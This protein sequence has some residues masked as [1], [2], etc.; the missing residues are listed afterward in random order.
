MY[1]PAKLHQNP[2]VKEIVED[3]S[4]QVKSNLQGFFTVATNYQ[5][6]KLASKLRTFVETPENLTMLNAYAIG[7]APSGGG[8]NFSMNRI[9]DEYLEGFNRG[10]TDYLMP[11]T[12]HNKILELA[13]RRSVMNNTSE[14]DEISK[15]QKEL[16]ATGE[17]LDIAEKA[18]P[19]A[20]LQFRQQLLINNCG[21]LNI[22]VDEVASA[23]NTKEFQDCI[24]PLLTLY[25]KGKIE[26]SLVKN[27]NDAKRFSKIDGVTPVNSFFM[28]TPDTL[29]GDDAKCKILADTLST[30]FARRSIFSFEDTYER[31][32]L[33]P[34]ERV[35]AVKKSAGGKDFIKKMNR[36]FAKFA[37]MSKF[38]QRIKLTD[39]DALITL[40]AYTD[41]CLKEAEQYDSAYLITNSPSAILKAEL[42]NREQRIIRFAALYAFLENK[43]YVE[44]DH[45]YQAIHL[46]EMSGEALKKIV[47]KTPIYEM[48]AKY[49]AAQS[50]E[51]VI[52]DLIEAFHNFPKS[53]SDREECLDNAQAWGQRNNIVIKRRFQDKIQYISGE[54]LQ[55][56]D[57]NKLTVA[58]SNH[59]AYD[60]T[61]GEMSWEKL[62][63]F[64]QKPRL[65]WINHHL[66][67]TK[68]RA[69][70]NVVEGFNLL[71]LDVD[72]TC[73]LDNA[74]H[75]MQEYQYLIYTTKRHGQDDKDR[76]RIVLPMLYNIKLNA[77]D[78]KAFMK[79]VYEWL[80]FDVDS[81]TGQ[82]ARKWLTNPGKVYVN[83]GI[84]I[85]PL[86]F[87]PCTK[88]NEMHQQQVKSQEHLNNI[89]RWI[90]NRADTEAGRN[91]MLARYAFILV[92]NGDSFANV[93]SKILNIN[94]QL[95]CPLS[96]SELNSTVFVTT[97]ERIH[98][99][100][101][102]G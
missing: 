10:F 12:Q 81:E 72:G 48:V 40:Y 75:F 55:E 95:A 56:T 41:R 60:Y 70:E 2:L 14:E 83:E 96:E 78:Y 27:T 61:S 66:N 6:M 50:G 20:I 36:F 59:V 33:T 32:I 79:N 39:D 5:L 51:L 88:D 24:K 87:I 16:N 86:P 69:D 8:K 9:Y 85:D 57:L 84:L 1:N 13:G 53:R 52:P 26:G 71:I 44:V 25:D 91:N 64:V 43:E 94:S 21:A 29:M 100:I 92:D 34:E 42:I 4:T 46:I 82:R 102:N 90:I 22:E 89:E 3:L 74:L 11:K 80:P 62:E 77:E 7:F 93:K 15:L 45:I 76:F 67:H 18:T 30:G 99:R 49:T 101:Q 17:Y 23:L 47:V 65:H 31:Q 37:D 28:G 54:R 35:K 63:A 97:Q 68:H 38:N 19:A 98:N 58:I 73:S